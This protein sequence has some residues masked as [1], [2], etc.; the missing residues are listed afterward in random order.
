[1]KLKT[2]QLRI[3]GC[4]SSSNCVNQLEGPQR[5]SQLMKCS[6]YKRWSV[7]TGASRTK[8]QIKPKFWA[9]EFGRKSAT[10]TTTEIY[11]QSILI[12]QTLKLLQKNCPHPT[13]SSKNCSY[14]VRSLL[15]CLI[16]HRSINLLLVYHLNCLRPPKLLPQK[17]QVK[18]SL[19]SPKFPLISNL[20]RMR[21]KNSTVSKTLT[22]IFAPLRVKSRETLLNA[23]KDNQ[24]WSR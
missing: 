4:Y 16:S 14:P 19:P 12:N 24:N 20:G 1:M 10:W 17:G 23:S 21:R 8:W 22:L 18:I 3:Q 6:L 15:A 7:S 5:D 11:A 9:K 13:S 2:D